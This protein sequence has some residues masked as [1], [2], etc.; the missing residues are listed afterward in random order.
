MPRFA[1]TGNCLNN[2]EILAD[3]DDELQQ[4]PTRPIGLHNI[5]YQS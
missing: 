2:K 3:V 5:S 1:I 4:E